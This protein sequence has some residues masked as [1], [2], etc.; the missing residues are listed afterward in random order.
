MT[1]GE[2]FSIEDSVSLLPSITQEHPWWTQTTEGRTEK[3]KSWNHSCRIKTRGVREHALWCS[4]L[5]IQLPQHRSRVQS[6]A[7]CSG[8]KDLAL[9]QLVPVPG[10]PQPWPD[11]KKKGKRNS[12]RTRL[13]K[14]TWTHHKI[15]T[16]HSVSTDRPWDR[17]QSCHDK[18]ERQI[19][20]LQLTPQPGL[21]MYKI[22]TS[23]SLLNWE[24]KEIS[25]E[26]DSDGLLRSRTQSYRTSVR[27]N[28]VFE[29]GP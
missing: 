11:K 7:S 27:S 3:P 14:R 26:N 17:E 2:M 25:P 23:K 29:F 21:W 20:S 4:G 9:L 18:K 24:L 5:R 28:I 15:N 6:L 8:F 12:R 13:T 1:G 10:T 16:G 19:A 22:Y